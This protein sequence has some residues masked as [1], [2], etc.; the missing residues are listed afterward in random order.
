MSAAVK[1]VT[2][3]VDTHRYDHLITE[4]NTPVESWFTAAHYRLLVD[5]LYA[6]WPGPP[7]GGPFI[8]DANVG[9]FDH[10]REPLP[11]VV[12]DI[13][14]SLGVS[15]PPDLHRKG[16]RSY[17]IWRFGK[18]PDATVEIVSDTEGGEDGWKLKHY[19]KIKV[20]YYI[21][22]DPRKHLHD[23][24][25]RVFKLVRGKYKLLSEPYWMPD[26]G[27][28]LKL[29]EGEY[30]GKHATWLRW[31][32]E[33]GNVIPTGKEKLSQEHQ[34]AELEHQ[35]AEAEHQ[36]AEEAARQAE[37]MRQRAEQLAAKL[38]ALGIDPEG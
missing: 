14:L 31:C 38:R 37:Q 23:Q 6:S 4:D 3:P 35:R 12:P 2:P 16:N 18:P 34:R 30:E 28:G 8:A 17:F 10:D 9:L 1:P 24:V 22:F 25:L 32:D 26:L 19:A 27:L 29:W 20:R 21:I 5:P 36:R 33:Q 7:A 11:T 13:L 15:L